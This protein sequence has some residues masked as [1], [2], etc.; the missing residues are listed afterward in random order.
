MNRSG[1]RGS[2]DDGP[3]GPPRWSD[4]LRRCEQVL[5]QQGLLPGPGTFDLDE[6][7]EQLQLSRRRPIHLTPVRMPADSEATVCGVCISSA[8]ADYVFYAH[9]LSA[10][11]STHNAVHELCHLVFGHRSVAPLARPSLASTWARSIEDTATWLGGREPSYDRNAELE[12]DAAAGLLLSRSE[13]RAP[14]E[15]ISS[16]IMHVGASRLLDAFG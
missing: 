3:A 8:R 7:T 16:S 1:R 15:W 4:V 9:T 14:Q 12:A 2:G 6:F 11:H 13:V 5:S 10:L